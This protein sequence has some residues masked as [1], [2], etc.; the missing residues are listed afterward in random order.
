MTGTHS[1]WEELL[2]FL[3]FQLLGGENPTLD[4]FP[5]GVLAFSPGTSQLGWGLAPLS[6]PHPWAAQE[7]LVR[8]ANSQT[9]AQIYPIRN[10]GGGT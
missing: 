7:K 2:S 6:Q 9:P 3:Q 10:S 1:S 8:N 5:A 4:D